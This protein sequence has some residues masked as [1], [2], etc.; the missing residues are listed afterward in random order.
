MKAGSALCYLGST[1]HGGGANRTS[2]ERRRG[3]FVGYVLGWLR[4]EENMFP[5]VPLEAVRA[6]PLR[7]QELLGYK[8]QRAMGAVDVGSPMALLD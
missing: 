8:A 5:S 7:I 6:M 2:D 4:T 3:L 1:L